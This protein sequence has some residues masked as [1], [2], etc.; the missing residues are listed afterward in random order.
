MA[1]RKKKTDKP[2]DAIIECIESH[3]AQVDV[4]PVAVARG[5]RLK[6]SHPAV[7]QNPNFFIEDAGLDDEHRVRQQPVR[8]SEPDPP[9]P[10]PAAPKLMRATRDLRRRGIALPGGLLSP[11]GV[12]TIPAG[13]L[14]PRR[15]SLS[16]PRRTHSRKSRTSENGEGPAVRPLRQAARGTVVGSLAHALALHVVQRR[17][18]EG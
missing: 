9:P 7:Q 3:V 16:R 4:V 8:L 15:T 12:T 17:P 10:R 14:L 5:T 6:G 1:T 2:D 13:S 18:R 11:H